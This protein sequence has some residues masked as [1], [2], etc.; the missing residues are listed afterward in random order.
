[1]QKTYMNL[2]SLA[3]A[4]ALGCVEQGGQTCSDTYIDDEARVIPD[5]A[6]SGAAHIEASFIQGPDD[7]ATIPPSDFVLVSRLTAPRT[8]T[9]ADADT[10]LTTKL[11][12]RDVPGSALLLRRE[13]ETALAAFDGTGKGWLELQRYDDGSGE[14][15][16]YVVAWSGAVNVPGDP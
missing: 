7:D 3:C 15:R 11:F 10:P 14:D 6:P 5:P 12:A 1:M 13:N 2:L 9:V 8:W 16:W 4:L